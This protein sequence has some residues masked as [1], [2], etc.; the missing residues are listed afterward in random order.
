MALDGP[1]QRHV[2]AEVHT[3]AAQAGHGRPVAGDS[4]SGDTRERGSGECR[5][6]LNSNIFSN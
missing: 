4:L 5:R 2:R 1:Q 3:R 6:Y